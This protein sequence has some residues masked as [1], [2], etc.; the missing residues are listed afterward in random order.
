MKKQATTSQPSRGTSSSGET[1]ATSCILA[2]T[3]V[4]EPQA[5]N[6][7]VVVTGIQALYTYQHLAA[8]VLWNFTT[9]QQSL[10]VQQ[11]CNNNDNIWGSSYESTSDE[12]LAKWR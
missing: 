6:A 3:L 11:Q 8:L 5:E 2:A 7:S 9:P 10:S 1:C 4:G 12:S